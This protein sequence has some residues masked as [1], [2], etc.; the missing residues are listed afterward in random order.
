VLE[1]GGVDL[2]EVGMALRAVIAVHHQPVLRLVLGVEQPLAVDGELVL[3]L[4][5]RQRRKR[6]AGQH[7]GRDDSKSAIAKWHVS[8]PV[9]IFLCRRFLFSCSFNGK[10][11]LSMSRSS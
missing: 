5:G 2:G 6:Y 10:S 8:S 7:S 1:V 9:G 11:G 4:R 3:R